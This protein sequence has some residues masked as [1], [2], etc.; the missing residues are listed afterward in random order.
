MTRRGLPEDTER[1]GARPGSAPWESRSRLAIFDL[2]GTLTA[3]DVA[4]SECFARAVGDEFGF[5]IDTDWSVYRHCT[6]AGIAAEA[7]ATHLDRP[8]TGGEIARLQRRFESLLRERLA[9]EPGLFTEVPGARD[10]LLRLHELGWHVCI[11]TGAWSFSA[12]LK[13][14]AAA[15]PAAIPLFSSDL[16]AAREDIIASAIESSERDGPAGRFGSIVSVGDGVWDVTAAVRLGLPFVGVGSGRR[17]RSLVEAGARHVVPDL[18]DT[19]GVIALLQSAS[20]PSPAAGRLD[21]TT[22]IDVPE[23][24]SLPMLEFLSW[25][26]TRD[27]TYSEAMEAWAS[28]CPRHTVWEDALIDGLIQLAS[29]GRVGERA[30]A[31]TARG[32]ETLRQARKAT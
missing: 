25:V 22:P 14:R 9:R 7:L 6:D 8:P 11:A 12:E 4:D 10:L 3:T 2:D 16:H 5:A 17:A 21:W 28:T 30:V 26:A 13:R 32:R 24:P 31:L 1:R 18:R 20:V 23:A 15:I 27:R 19:S 29:E